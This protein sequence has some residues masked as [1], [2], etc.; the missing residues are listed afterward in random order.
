MPGYQVHKLVNPGQ[1][2]AVLWVGAIQIR[3]VDAHSPFSICLF[4]HENIGQLLRIV[5]FSYKVSNE[6]LVQLVHN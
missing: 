2:E 4:D 5:D 1:R 6:Q 3:E